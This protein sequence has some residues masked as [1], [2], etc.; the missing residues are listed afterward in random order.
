LQDFVIGERARSAI[1]EIIDH[2]HRA[3]EAAYRLCAQCGPKPFVQCAAFVGFKVADPI[4]R[5]FAG[6]MMEATPPAWT[7]TSS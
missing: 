4:Q 2:Y 6:S 3:N 5:S 7:E 1:G